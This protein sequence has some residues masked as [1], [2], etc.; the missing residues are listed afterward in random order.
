MTAPTPDPARLEN[1]H[2]ADADRPAPPP[3]WS[4]ASLAV[5][6]LQIV[7]FVVGTVVIGGGAPNVLWVVA[8]VL[9]V[10][11]LRRREGT[12]ARAALA[13]SL[14]AALMPVAVMAATWVAMILRG[15]VS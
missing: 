11:G 15:F 7:A 13:A 9:A 5:T 10:V 6:G 4:V 14:V 2:R 3:R 8:L 1:A 12:L